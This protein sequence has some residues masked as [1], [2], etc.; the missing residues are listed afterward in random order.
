MPTN[1]VSTLPRMGLY[2]VWIATGNPRQPLA[3]IWIDPRMRS[4]GLDYFQQAPI[5]RVESCNLTN[6]IG[7]CRDPKFKSSTGLV[8]FEVSRLSQ[9]NGKRARWVALVLL[10][11]SVLLNL[12]WADVGGQIIGVV[13]DPSSAFISRATVTLTN[14]DNGTKQTGITND[15]AQ[16][17]FPVVPVG[18]YELEISAPGFQTHK[19]TGIGIDVNT[20]LQI[21]HRAGS[22]VHSKHPV[23]SRDRTR[24]QHP[25]MV[26]GDWPRQWLRR[27]VFP[28]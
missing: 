1:F 18:K 17:S 24:P 19:K 20:V 22:R 14:A 13:T 7:M 28:R 6:K 15:R 5:G 25:G 10:A 12:A 2:C 27:P 16:Y 9:T 4:Y 8:S 23:R 3:C 11:L 21:V 26:L